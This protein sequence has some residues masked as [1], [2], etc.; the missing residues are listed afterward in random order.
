MIFLQTARNEQ[1]RFE[2]YN[3]YQF[4]C[5]SQYGKNEPVN[6]KQIDRICKALQCK[7]ED[8]IEYVNK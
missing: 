7:I 3:R 8:V 5:N 4:W 2:K 1:R 6:L